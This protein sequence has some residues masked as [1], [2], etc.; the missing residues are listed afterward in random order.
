[1]SEAKAHA[2]EHDLHLILTRRLLY[3]EDAVDIASD[4]LELLKNVIT[5][6]RQGAVLPIR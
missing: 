4:A 3:F 5:I 1:M 6:R 2:Y